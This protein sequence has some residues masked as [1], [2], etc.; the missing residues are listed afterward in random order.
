MKHWDV[1]FTIKAQTETPSF[2]EVKKKVFFCCGMMK[3]LLV[4]LLLVGLIMSGS[5]LK[6]NYCITSG[7]GSTCSVTKETCGYKKDACISAFFTTA[8]YSRFRRCIAMS[9]CEI[10]KMLSN[11]NFRCCQTDLCN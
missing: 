1:L 10:M 4:T 5:A 11:L 9:D 6:C 2:S 3:I 8:P 7:A